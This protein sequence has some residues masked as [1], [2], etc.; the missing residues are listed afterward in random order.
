MEIEVGEYV[1]TSKGSIGKFL[2]Y[3]KDDLELSYIKTNHRMICVDTTEIIKHSKNIIDLI[4]VG[5]YVNGYKVT[6]VIINPAPSGKCVDIDSYR[7]SE[8]CTIWKDDIKTIL[9][10]EQY[11]QNCYKVKE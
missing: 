2:Y 5:N 3:G 6:N 10:H 4:E 1:R 7:P 11:E 9:T 8:E